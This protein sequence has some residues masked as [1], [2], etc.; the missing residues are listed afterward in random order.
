MFSK[1]LRQAA[2]LGACSHVPKRGCTSIR[3][4]PTSSF[5]FAQLAAPGHAGSERRTR[6]RTP[7]ALP[8][9]DLANANPDSKPLASNGKPIAVLIRFLRFTLGPSK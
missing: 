1:A 3:L 7:R 6:D 5:N 2:P 4:P 8:V 9:L